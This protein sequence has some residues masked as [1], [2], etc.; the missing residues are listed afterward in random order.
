MAQNARRIRVGVI[1][2]GAIADTY[3]AILRDMPVFDLRACAE[4]DP[5][6]R[7]QVERSLALPVLDSAEALLAQHELDAVLVL[8]PPTSHERL[9]LLGLERG[10]HV[11]CEKPLSTAS[12]A[13]GR[14]VAAATAADRTLM[15]ASKFRFVEDVTDA[16][17]LLES[18]RLGEVALFENVFCSRVDMTRR[19]NARPE[20]SGGGVLIDNAP[21]SIDLARYLL[22]PIARVHAAFGRRLQDLPVE[23]T[24]RMQL[25]ASSGA[26]GTVD[27]SWSLHKEVG[28]YVRVVGANGTLELGWR[29]SRYKLADDADWTGF[30]SGY[31]KRQALQRNLDNFAQVV[32]GRDRPVSTTEDALWSVRIVDAAYQA[33]R[34]G[35]PVAL[36]AALSVTNPELPPNPEVRHE[37]PLRARRR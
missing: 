10:C 21:H 12:A 23:D 26:L 14:M 9:S 33:A 11:L 32:L 27:L 35:A 17:R 8:T 7:R 30:G 19:W 6:R 25:E 4:S 20:H 31:D 5:E 24:A 3:L 18:G 36:P 15:T 2:C 1:G 37:E 16:R 29:S 34:S 22:G 13:A 28:W